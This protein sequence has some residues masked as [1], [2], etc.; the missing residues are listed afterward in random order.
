[1]KDIIET[2][3]PMN[4]CL[5]GEGYDNALEYLKHLLDLEVIEI[6][7]GTKLGT[8]TVPDEWIVRDAWVKLNGEKI[9]DYQKQPLSLVIG[10]LPTHGVV[11]REE[12][13]NHLYYSDELPDATPYHFNYYDYKGDGLAADGREDFWGFCVPKSMV[14]QKMEEGE[15]DPTLGKIELD[16]KEYQL[17]YKD[18]LP[19]GQYEVMID[20]EYRPGVM[21]LGVHTIKGKSDRE[22]LLFAHL[23]HPFQANDNLSAVACLVDLAKKIKADHTIKIVFCPETIGSIGYAMTQD[24]SK[25]DFMIAVDICGNKDTLVMQK[26]YDA[27]NRLYRVGHVAIQGLGETYRQGPFRAT[28]GSDEYVFND[29]LIGIPGLMLSRFPYPEY[30]TSEDTP[31]KID[32]EMIEKTGVAIQKI[33]EVWEKDYIPK[34]EFKGPLMRSRYKIQTDSPQMNLSYDYFVYAIDGKRSLAELCCEYGLNF[35]FTYEILE[36]MI[37][38][39][40]ISRIDIGEGDKQPTTGKKHKGVSRETDVPGKRRKV[41]DS[42]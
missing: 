37:N 24:I 21:K 10:C 2:L 29:P 28:I 14:R 25:V 12:L 8:W 3:Y 27:E 15:V 17:K 26:P 5:L 34:R 19:E 7:S 31:D 22:I 38:D 32:Y 42:L 11:G 36:Q 30:H 23:D 35:E 13:R 41:S 18:V 4:R 9:I 16:G 6:K 1:M 40:T 20:T 33:I 39:G